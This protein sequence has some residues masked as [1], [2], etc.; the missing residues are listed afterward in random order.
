MKALYLYT[1]YLSKQINQKYSTNQKR[2]VYNANIM[3]LHVFNNIWN[4]FLPVVFVGEEN[5]EPVWKQTASMLTLAV[6]LALRG[7]SKTV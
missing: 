6:S 4:I 2:K 3:T 1:V 5:I 7:A